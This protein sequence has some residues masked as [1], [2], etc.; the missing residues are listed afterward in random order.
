MDFITT[1]KTLIQT[2]YMNLYKGFSFCLLRVI[3]L[4]GTVFMTIELLKKFLE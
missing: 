2:G 4:H 3:P 1:G